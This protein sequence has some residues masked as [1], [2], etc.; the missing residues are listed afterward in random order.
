VTKAI[1]ATCAWHWSIGH[2]VRAITHPLVLVLVHPNRNGAT[3]RTLQPLRLPPS[4]GGIVG[5]AGGQPAAI[6]AERNTCGMSMA[7]IGF[8]ARAGIFPGSTDRLAF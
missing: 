3:V 5:A 8:S 4:G 2:G 1:A 7:E 6:R